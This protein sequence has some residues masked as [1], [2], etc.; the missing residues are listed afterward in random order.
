MN[1]IHDPFIHKFPPEIS[2]HIFR[3]CFPTL[4]FED[5]DIWNK[6]AAFTRVLSLG[7]VC[8]KWR[9]L[10]WAT[11][12]LWDTLYVRIPPSPE[13]ALV[14][15]LPGLL[16]EWLSRSGMR[17][18]TIFFRY[19]GHS[20]KQDYHRLNDD[21]LDEST[22]ISL[23]PA[24]DLVIDIIN[25]HSG[26]WRNLHLDVGADIPQ[27]FCGSIH[28][29]QLLCL[30]LGINGKSFP[31]PK[32]VMK[33]KPFPTQLTLNSFPPTLID[34]GWENIT[35]AILCNLSVH[36]CL[37][38]LRRTPSLEYCLA[39]P[40][41]EATAEIGTTIN[42]HLR[43]LNVSSRGTTLLDAINVPSLEEWIYNTEGALLPVAAMVSLLKRSGCFLKILNLRHVKAPPDN[44]F[45]LFQ[46]LP[47]LERLQFDFFSAK[48]TMTVMDDILARI[49]N[50]RPGS[51]TMPSEGTSRQRFRPHLQFMECMT[52]ATTL[53]PFSWNLIPQ[54][55]RQGHRRSL[56]LRSGA[57][58]SHITHETALQLLKLADE[59]VDLQI[60]DKTTK[61]GGDFLENFRKRVCS[62]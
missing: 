16:R 45:I 26:R 37:A 7:A 62:L 30:E 34:I 60:L 43:S 3:L 21:F 55:Y 46:E 36:E 53:A 9:Q 13:H 35:H 49:S 4:D 32:F 24:A 48:N 1:A 28:S 41:R 10:A 17:P 20:R 31:T 18:L 33:S 58:E 2:S 22:A 27:L 12:D 5:L 42:P 25:F 38:V 54:L 56:T 23:D 29:N 61:A 50:T 47:S 6:A 51:S 40:W 8:Q 39:S 15:W 59:G 52:L 19:S 44:L 57:K 11:P 14:H